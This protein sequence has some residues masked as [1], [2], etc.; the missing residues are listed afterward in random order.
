MAHD[1]AIAQ[2]PGTPPPS[3][4]TNGILYCGGRARMCDGL[5]RRRE[6]GATVRQLSGLDASFYY[7][8]QPRVPN[9]IGPVYL[10]DPST[11][12]C[13][14]VTIDDVLALLERR[15]G[16]ARMFRERLVPVP[17]DLDHP[18]WI[19]DSDFDLEYH[20]RHI[21]L[22]AP[23]T[24]RQF[25]TQVARL[26]SRPLDLTRPPW[27]L[28]LIDG[29]D[30]VPG[31]PAGCF[32]TVMK[33]HHAAIDGVAGL[34]LVNAIH[35][36]APVVDEPVVA[37]SWAPEQPP[38]ALQLLA[39]AAM[40]NASSPV[41]MMR[42]TRRMIPGIGRA[43]SRAGGRT[44]SLSPDP[45]PITRFSGRVSAHRVFDGRSFS[46]ADVKAM[47]RAVEGAT[48]NDVALTLIGGA[49]RTY[50]STKDELPAESLVSMVPISV[51]PPGA[52][53]ESGNQISMM[54]VAIGTEIADPLERL[55]AT[56]ERT[57]R[58]KGLASA[59]GARTL[60]DMSEALPGALL[61]LG[62]RSF[63]RAARLTPNAANTTITNVPGVQHPV[64]FCGAEA[65]VGYG[66]GPIVDGM[67]L[68]NLIG[69]YKDDFLVSVSS[70]REMMPDVDFYVDCVQ[71]SYDALALA[72]RV[73]G[74]ARTDASRG[75]R[76]PARVT[77]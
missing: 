37:G 42:A 24:W 31:V 51:R 17:L 55:A 53:G 32:A 76:R 73:G 25:C 75:R 11:S 43:M 30:D 38:S 26:H 34:E 20:V 62:L 19:N 9:H 48:V 10:Y 6:Q 3:A 45:V 52:V 64:Y 5:I 28:Y 61:G 14:R 63:S 4:W 27:E 22:P 35:D 56:R 13:G 29:I 77:A 65:L 46:L 2:L 74:T 50:L 7:T 66:L 54:N 68:M 72:T 59:I 40:R 70:C 41:R 18:F 23:G 36:R 8:E 71:S 16:L 60:L 12:P 21:A 1:A 39:G 69:S 57:S 33:I 44:M 67:G 15:L 47:K 49:L 58:A